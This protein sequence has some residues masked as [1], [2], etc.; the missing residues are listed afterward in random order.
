MTYIADERALSI[1][2][3]ERGPYMITIFNAGEL[4]SAKIQNV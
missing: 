3:K 4:S 1:I 2:K